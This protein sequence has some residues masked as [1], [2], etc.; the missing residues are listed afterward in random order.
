MFDDDRFDNPDEF[1]GTCPEC[2]AEMQRVDSGY[3]CDYEC[4]Y[5]RYVCMKDGCDGD[6]HVEP[7]SDKIL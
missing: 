2:G 1:D 5:D 3:D 4:A 6:I 7:E